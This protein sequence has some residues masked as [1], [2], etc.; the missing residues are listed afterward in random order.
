MHTYILPA[1]SEIHFTPTRARLGHPRYYIYRI[2]VV[3]RLYLF[4]I[5]RKKECAH[6]ARHLAAARADYAER[7]C[8]LIRKIFAGLAPLSWLTNCAEETSPGIFRPL[9]LSLLFS[10]FAL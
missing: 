10:S 7:A 2:V 3:V 8:S 6:R 1:P 9:S 4:L 5:P